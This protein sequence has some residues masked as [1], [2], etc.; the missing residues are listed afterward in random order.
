MLAVTSSP[1]L[2]SV[3]HLALPKLKEIIDIRRRREEQYESLQVLV[4]FQDFIQFIN[5]LHHVHLFVPPRELLL[6]RW[7]ECCW[8]YRICFIFTT[9]CYWK[10]L[11]FIK[12]ELATTFLFVSF[13]VYHFK[14]IPHLWVLHCLATSHISSKS[15]N[16]FGVKISLR[17][18]PLSFR[19]L[20]RFDIL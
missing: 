16:C 10:V 20:S 14:F 2:Q 8:I 19:S 13:M 11:K 17:G 5:F 12:Q 3:S 6:A 9:L 1:L 4:G 7:Q 18:S 15:L